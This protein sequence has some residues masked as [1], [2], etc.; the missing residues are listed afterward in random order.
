[1]VQNLLR[2]WS[3][4]GQL[5]VP[6]LRD[7]VA[8]LERR[9]ARAGERIIAEGD[10]AGDMFLVEKGRLRVSS[11]RNGETLDLAFLRDGEYFGE[12]SLLTGAPRAAQVEALTDCRL[13][14]LSAEAFNALAAEHESFRQ[15]V[16]E[17]AAG[18]DYKRQAHIPLD[19]YDEI[20]P[21][22][23]LA[24][25]GVSPRQA[26]D[27]RD[28]AA[29]ESSEESGPLD[30]PFATSEGLFRWRG[31]RRVRKF[32]FLMQIDQMD[33][34]VACIAMICRYYG[35]KVSLARIRDLARTSIDGTSLRSLCR[36][37]TELGIA[38]R[39]VKASHRNLEQ[40][41]LPALAHWEGNHWA[42]LLEVR[43]KK[44]RVADPAQGDRWVARSEF[45]EKWSGYVGLFEPTPAFAKTPEEDISPLWLLGFLKPHAGTLLQAV[46][47][48]LAAS[49]LA[50]LMPVFSQLVVDRVIMAGEAR[51]LNGVL[52]AMLLTALLLCATQL[53]Q[54]Y[55]LAHVTLRVDASSL[56]FITRTLLDL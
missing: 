23:A 11:K 50:M 30:E 34:G 25:T 24:E 3:P 13:F 43:K 22:S 19:F 40:L 20:A 49:G 35:R 16:R 7:L 10:P 45:E 2:R 55:L 54:R 14:T 18:D 52:A 47:L 21:A 51:L 33:C 17:R 8:R 29:T 38:S 4:L 32:P 31:R 28:P 12:L 53:L 48:A 9:E 37:A 27:V 1:T 44:V 39:S 26:E 6:V 56:D 42:C 5:P 15:L 41:P 46:L 36:A